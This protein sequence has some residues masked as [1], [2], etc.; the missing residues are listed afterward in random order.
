L[1]AFNNCKAEEWGLN[2]IG[3]RRAED[4]SMDMK[5]KFGLRG[6]LEKMAKNS[7]DLLNFGGKNLEYEDFSC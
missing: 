2:I 3:K 4:L 1:D 5:K 6:F 7:I